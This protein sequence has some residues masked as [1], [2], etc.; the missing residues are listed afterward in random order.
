MAYEES[1]TRKSTEF[2]YRACRAEN[3]AE[4]DSDA[5]KKARS[6]PKRLVFSFMHMRRMIRTGIFL[7][8]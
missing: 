4:R 6:R 2:G 7:I 5:G 8:E 3:V 1:G